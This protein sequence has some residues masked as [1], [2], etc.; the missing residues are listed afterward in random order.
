LDLT[1][2]Q[3]LDFLFL[4]LFRNLL[5]ESRPGTDGH[6]AR[7]AR[8]ES[9]NVGEAHPADALETLATVPYG[10]KQLSLRA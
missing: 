3:L 10:L 2:H 8:G 9:G 6:Q 1:F 7:R 5:G 4:L